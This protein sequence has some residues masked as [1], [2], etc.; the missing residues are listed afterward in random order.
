[1]IIDFK[2]IKTLVHDYLDHQH[3]NDILDFNPTAENIAE[4]ICN[5]VPTC[6]KVD[7][8]ESI[9]NTVTYERDNKC[10]CSE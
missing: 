7:V 4:W 2:K 5:R 8:Q 3:L 10:L 1:M 6:Y 9:G